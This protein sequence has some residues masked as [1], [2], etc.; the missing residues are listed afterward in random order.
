M[1][2]TRGGRG[3]HGRCDGVQYNWVT[4]DLKFNIGHFF[5][6]A[7]TLLPVEIGFFLNWN[8]LKIVNNIFKFDWKFFNYLKKKMLTFF[9]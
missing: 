7:V 3:L 5:P 9:I 8:M 4:S 6:K 2:A 1:T